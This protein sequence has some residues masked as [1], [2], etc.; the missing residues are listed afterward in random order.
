MD[1]RTPAVS[2][3]EKLVKILPDSESGLRLSIHA[4]RGQHT[5]ITSEAEFL[6]YR[7]LYKTECLCI[8]QVYEVAEAA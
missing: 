5:S 8:E 1:G 4:G 2:P 6:L 7:R 3:A